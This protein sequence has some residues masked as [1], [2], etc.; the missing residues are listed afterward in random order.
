MAYF[1]E[2]LIIIGTTKNI[3]IFDYKNFMNVKTIFCVY[4]IKKIFVNKNKL[5]IGESTSYD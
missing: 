1:S 3:E 2:N 4:P 5:F